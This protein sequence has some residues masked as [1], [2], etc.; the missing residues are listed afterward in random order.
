MSTRIEVSPISREHV[1][2][3]TR[4][5]PPKPAPTR[6][7]AASRATVEIGRPSRPAAPP[8]TA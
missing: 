7:G 5:P 4:R 3:V 2:G 1:P 6:D 8:A